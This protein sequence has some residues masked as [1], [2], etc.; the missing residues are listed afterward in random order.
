MAV[1]RERM[2][3]SMRKMQAKFDKEGL[4]LKVSAMPAYDG[5]KE[6][7]DF[8]NRDPTYAANSERPQQEIRAIVMGV[9]DD[10]HL[11]NIKEARAFMAKISSACI[12]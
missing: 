7:L 1:M 10:G 8:I 12:V 5:S 11:G 4:Q 9:L 3:S 2:A 6:N